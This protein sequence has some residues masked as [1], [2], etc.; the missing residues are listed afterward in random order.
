VKLRNKSIII[1]GAGR[2]LGRAIAHAT[3]R[4]GAK[5]TLM[6]RSLNELED[7]AAQIRDGGGTCLVS[8]GDVSCRD[9]VTH[10]VKQAADRF[11]TVDVLINNA[12]VIGPVRFREDA[13]PKAWDNTIAI[14]LNGAYLCARA[15]LPFMIQ[16]RGGKIIN[17]A[18]GLGQMPFPKLCAYSVS[19]AGIIQLTR[20]L[21]ME[22]EPLNIQVNAI[23][24]GM[25]DTK[26]QERIRSFGPAVLGTSVHENMM[27]YK[28]KNLLKDPAEIAALA[29]ILASS[30]A[31]RLSG[32]NGTLSEYANLGYGR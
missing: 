22:L 28:N 32:Y 4:E 8:R 18:S 7:V 21:S 10:T 5:V 19:K 23:D 20:S 27:E 1:T 25:M 6:S 30:K 24:P 3:S 26:L 17:I 9:D 12:A 11:S 2:G 29:V 16:N 15:V 13:D 14:N 31:D